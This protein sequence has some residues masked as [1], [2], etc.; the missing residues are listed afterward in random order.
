MARK[1]IYDNRFWSGVLYCISWFFLKISGWKVVGELPENRKLVL[2]GAPHTSNWDFVVLMCMVG[3]K[4]MRVS[5]L[6]KHTLFEGPFSW[7]FYYV[8]GVPVDRKS[9]DAG[10]IVEQVVDE[11]ETREHIWLG[12]SPEGTRKKVDKWKTGFHRIASAAQVPVFPIFIDGGNKTVGY[13]DLMDLSEDVDSDIAR[14]KAFYAQFRGI[15]PEN[16]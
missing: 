7:F 12:V 10:D 4:R 15:R 1:V 14:L 9:K 16:Q 11:F 8:G 3:Y 5:F 13:G 6:G 2:V